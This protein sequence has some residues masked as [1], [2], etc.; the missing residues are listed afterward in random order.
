MLVDR[1]NHGALVHVV[2]ICVSV[3]KI[4]HNAVLP[5]LKDMV[6]GL[7]DF[8]VEK[9]GA[10]K[11]FALNQNVVI[12]FPSSENCLRGI[13]DLVR[14]DVCGPMPLTSFIGNIY[15]VSFIDDSSRKT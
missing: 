11:R 14:L 2:T 8:K 1:M 5:Y 12:A 3:D 9:R 7:L 4:E 13:L 15:Y 10:C 6:V